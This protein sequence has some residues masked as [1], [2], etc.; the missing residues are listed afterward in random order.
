[1]QTVYLDTSVLG[2]CFDKEFEKWSNALIEEFQLG[3]KMAIISDVTLDELESAPPKVQE[4]LSKIPESNR[5]FI[6]LSDEGVELANEYVAE[7]AVTIKYYEDALHI[8]L[9]TVN[10]CKS[11]S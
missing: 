3:L 5:S 1:M 10:H 11:L 9:A 2:G 8:A 6:P 7:G 4:V